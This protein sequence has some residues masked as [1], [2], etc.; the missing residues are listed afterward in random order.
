MSVREL[1]GWTPRTFTR[2]RY[3]DGGRLIETVSRQESRWTPSEVAVLLASRRENLGPHGIP[4]DQALDPTNKNRFEVEAVRDFAQA[5]LNR[6][7]ATYQDQY[8]HD[9]VDSIQFHVTLRD[10]E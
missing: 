10:E 5:E 3:D 4:M 9:D 2:H 6:V 7:K 1:N 8:K